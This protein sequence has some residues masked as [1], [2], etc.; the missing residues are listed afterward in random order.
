MSRH[1]AIANTFSSSTIYTKR[2]KLNIVCISDALAQMYDIAT[3]CP[4]TACSSITAVYLDVKCE[5][6][7]R[8]LNN[9]FAN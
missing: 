2:G 8:K 4:G 9:V 5:K 3:C 1:W 6:I 7:K